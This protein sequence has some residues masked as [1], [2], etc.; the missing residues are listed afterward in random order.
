MAVVGSRTFNDYNL[1]KEKLDK[2]YPN[3]QLIV[4]GG[5]QGADTFAERYA[6]EEGIPTLIIYP[7]WKKYGKAAGFIRNKD[8]V[9][10]SD[11]VVA[12]WDGLSKGT[13]N[14]IDHAKDLG[15]QLIVVTF[16]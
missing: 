2:Q 12:F 9:V 13:K 16:S 7:E 4:S 15:K 11:T 6:Q 3:I 5:A 14:S 1:L 8:I 10:A